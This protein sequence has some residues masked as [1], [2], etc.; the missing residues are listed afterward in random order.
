MLTAAGVRSEDVTRQWNRLRPL[1]RAHPH[2][3]KPKPALYEWSP[4]AHPSRVSLEALSAY[5][6]R[7]GPAWLVR[8][9]ADNI[10]D[11]L[12][13]AETTGPRAQIG[14]SEQ[15]DQEKAALLAELVGTVDELA[16]EGRSAHDIVSWLAQEADRSHL[17]A[18]GHVG[19]QAAFD[20]DLHD[21]SGPDG[22]R[23]G[24]VVRVVRP[25]Y[26]W[27]GGSRPVVVAKALVA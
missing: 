8:A 11:S 4:V 19:E 18:I 21:S 7:R 15:R 6:G 24:Q 14:W 10:A 22:H 27:S 5:A 26:S 1:F 16:A 20:P 13:R 2:I 3:S 12:A 9:Y 23:P 17:T 25:G